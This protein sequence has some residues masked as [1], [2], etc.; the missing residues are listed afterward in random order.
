MMSHDERLNVREIHWAIKWQLACKLRKSPTLPRIRTTEQK[1]LVRFPSLRS[2]SP[3]LD[4][5]WQIRPQSMRLSTPKLSMSAEEMSSQDEFHLTRSATRSDRHSKLLCTSYPDSPYEYEVI[6]TAFSR[7]YQRLQDTDG[8]RVNG[9]GDLEVHINNIKQYFLECYVNSQT[10]LTALCSAFKGVHWVDS[11]LFLTAVEHVQQVNYDHAF[12]NK[13]ELA[14]TRNNLIRQKLLCKDYV[15]FF[16]LLD[17]NQ[18]NALSRFE[19]K[20]VSAMALRSNKKVNSESLDM[21]VD[22]AFTKANESRGESSDFISFEEF[23]TVLK[24]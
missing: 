4:G 12:F 10:F 2:Y 13:D 5:S 23:H 17:S 9:F 7:L 16:K 20:T 1:S 3:E 11:H 19:V 14:T 18:K 21:V 24:G 8:V 6:E 15:V 22:K